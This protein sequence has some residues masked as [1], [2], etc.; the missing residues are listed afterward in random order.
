VNWSLAGVLAKR[1][2]IILK[3][4]VVGKLLRVVVECK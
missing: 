3:L 1:R 2:D 4:V